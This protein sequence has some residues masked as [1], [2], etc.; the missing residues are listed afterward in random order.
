VVAALR[1]VVLL[2]S[3]QMGLRCLTAMH[4]ARPDSVAGVVTVD[5]TDDSR[6]A[7]HELRVEGG[8]TAW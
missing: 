3:K 7:L 5:D 1:R 2:G 6:H 8:F 4:R